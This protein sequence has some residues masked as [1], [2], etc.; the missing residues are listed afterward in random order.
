MKEITRENKSQKRVPKFTKEKVFLVMEKNA[1][2]P[3]A[4][5][6]RYGA[7]VAIMLYYLD[8]ISGNTVE[9]HAPPPPMGAGLAQGGQMTVEVKG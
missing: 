9:S 3:G 2:A 7:P 8:R 5:P 1:D 4:L 6:R